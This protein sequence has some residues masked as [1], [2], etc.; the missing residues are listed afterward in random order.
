[1]NTDYIQQ[2]L[3]ASQGNK[4]LAVVQDEHGMERIVSAKYTWK[5]RVLHTL[6]SV[7]VLKSLTCVKNFLAK[8]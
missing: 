2:A 5:D 8:M 3:H 4:Q 1:M 6:S 7:P